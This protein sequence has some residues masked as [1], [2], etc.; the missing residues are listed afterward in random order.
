[1]YHGGGCFSSVMVDGRMDRTIYR[2]ILE[3]AAELG[4]FCIEDWENDSI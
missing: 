3:G 1:M 2:E 4:L